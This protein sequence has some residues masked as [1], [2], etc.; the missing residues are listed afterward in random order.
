MIDKI[1]NIGI[2]AHIDAGK[3]TT[4]ERM[5]FYTGKTYK[6]GGVDDGNT[7]TD[8][9][10][11]ERERGITIIS[12][13]TTCY[14]KDHKINLIDTPGHVDFTVEV[15][16][17]LR[18]VDGALG[19]FCSV[20]GVQPQSETVWRQSERYGIPR[21]IFINKMDRKGADFTRV[22]KEIESK[23][24]SRTLIMQLP[25]LKGE[26]L[27]GIIDLVQ[28]NYIEYNDDGN[29]KSAVI[30]E[31]PPELS[32]RA[33]KYRNRLIERI[34]D[35]DE[36]IM[37][38]YIDGKPVSAEKIK[39]VVRR[40]VLELKFFPCFAGTSL[41]DKGTVLLLDAIVDYLPSPADRGDIKGKN[42]HTGKE[43]T[44]GVDDAFSGYV[45]KVYNEAHL[46]KLLYTRI[47]SG[48]LK[49][50]TQVYNCTRDHSEKINKIYEVSANKFFEKDVVE[51]G[52]IVAVSGLKNTLTGDT[53]TG[54]ASRIVFESIDFP[55]PVIHVSIEPKVKSDQEKVFTTLK[56]LIEED[57]SI[58][59][60]IDPE[61][62]QILLMGMGELHIQVIA[63]RIK[64]E[65]N[66]NIR[67]GT[68]EVAY[69]ETLMAEASGEGKFIKQSGGRGHYGH[70]VI[71]VEPIAAEE[72]FI[73]ESTVGGDRIPKEF[74]SAVKQGVL[75]GMEA[76]PVLGCPVINVKVTVTD[77]SYH[78]VDSNEIAYK[79][80]GSIAFQDA[81]RKAKPV[82]LEPI[83]WIEIIVPE[84][85]LGAVLADFNMRQGKVDEIKET[86]ALK[87][88][89][90]TVPLRNVFGYA[91]NLRSLTQGRGNYIIEPLHYEPA[92]E[93]EIKRLTG[94]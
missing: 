82:L 63:E 41:K 38:S 33:L 35:E 88:I 15:E 7:V 17:S 50:G 89:K 59:A 69:R 47:Y 86:D 1:R 2:I 60:K 83:M 3:T 91:T 75:E 92:P 39:S 29:E 58:K 31:V 4:S 20:G 94:L 79:I 51:A 23:L 66:L 27:A 10:D 68:P 44:R 56:K 74:I 34:A 81:C 80:A 90:G 77:G 76:G 48:N 49:R 19:I 72:K 9:M 53:L 32:A 45:F 30:K 11:Q 6:K 71:K 61:T 16:R 22:V 14:W 26:T 65:Y 67:I 55:E 5:L 52:E 87:I 36:D 8:W 57:P 42:P 73:F 64:R 70:V 37:H 13:A 21:I 84:E 43:E 12:A 28:N 46:G 85:F 24:N 62:G 93:S 54:K 18:V 40:G 78:T 25:I